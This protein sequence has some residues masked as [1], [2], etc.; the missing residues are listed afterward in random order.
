MSPETVW[1]LF[2]RYYRGTDTGTS[3]VGSGLGMAV[4]RGLIEAM[5]G[6]IEVSSTPGEGT[7]IRLIWMQSTPDID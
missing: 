2:E 6:R 5:K 4:T 7:T 1:K 3:D